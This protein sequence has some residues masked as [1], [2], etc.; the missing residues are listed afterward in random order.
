MVSMSGGGEGLG[1]AYKEEEGSEEEEEEN[2]SRK[3]GI[4][5]DVL[6]YSCKGIENCQGL[7]GGQLCVQRT[8]QPEPILLEGLGRVP[9]P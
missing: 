1:Q 2:G 4:V 5:H 3:V 6:V 7:H 8:V 9:F